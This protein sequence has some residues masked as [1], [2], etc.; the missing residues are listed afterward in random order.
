MLRVEAE[1]GKQ[2]K[3][4]SGV[5]ILGEVKRLEDVIAEG[6]AIEDEADVEGAGELFVDLLEDFVGEAFRLQRGRID[7]RSAF[8]GPRA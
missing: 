3:P 1:R 2:I 7:M 6:P 8:E 4:G 5:L